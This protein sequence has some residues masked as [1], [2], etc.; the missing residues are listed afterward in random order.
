MYCVKSH[1]ASCPQ[2]LISNSCFLLI[3]SFSTFSFNPSN[4]LK[5]SVESDMP[6]LHSQ[7]K[8]ALKDAV[9]IKDPLD[10]NGKARNGA[11]GVLIHVATPRNS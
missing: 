3:E 9:F 1:S 7:G 2:M 6:I 4:P 11:Q 5:Q 10:R 8:Q